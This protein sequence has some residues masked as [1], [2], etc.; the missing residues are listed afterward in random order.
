MSGVPDYVRPRGDIT[1]VLDQA[2]RDTQD[3]FLFPIDSNISWFSAPIKRRTINFTPQIQSFVH[4]GPAQ[5]GG[6]FT[7]E[8]DKVSAGD[9]IHMVALRVRLGH[10][11]DAQTLADLANNKLIYQDPTADAWTYANAI[12]RV[13]VESAEIQVD[14]TVLETVDSVAADIILKLYPD[15]N[16]IFGYARDGVG[17]TTLPELV[18]APSTTA[19]EEPTGMFDP[20]RPFTTENGEIFC[21]IPFFFTRNPYRTSFPL[22]SIIKE[23]TT[24]INL[25]LRPFDQCVRRCS[26]QRSSCTETP[27]NR[28]ITFLQQPS[29]TPVQI[30]TAA[31]PPTFLDAQLMVYS[32]LLDDTARQQYIRHPFEMMYRELQSFPFSQP[33]KYAVASTNSAADNVRVQLPLE[34]NHPVE[35]ILWVVRRRTAG[36]NNNWL[37]FGP[38]S[39]AQA[40]ASPAALPIEPIILATIYINGIPI[41]EQPGQWYRHHIAEAHKGGITPYQTFVYGYSFARTPGAFSPSGTANMSRANSVRLD[42]TVRVPRADTSAFNEEDEQTWEVFVYGLAI[43]WLRFQN[44]MCGRMFTT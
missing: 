1:T 38:L 24:R 18:T 13:L 4:K 42:L 25:N 5:W 33:L 2:D 21:V 23:G 14:D 37:N 36:V 26:G 17:F 30:N 34:F 8:I 39:E 31:E 44:G 35:E 20:R 9:L 10:W 7:F 15:L 3:D 11:L 16:N 29:G 41:T 27:L 43:N 40:K 19:Q 6:R 12:G 32:S 28:T 22:L